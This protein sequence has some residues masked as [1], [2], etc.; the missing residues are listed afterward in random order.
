M[1]TR[2]RTANADLYHSSAVHSPIASTTCEKSMPIDFLEA[3]AAKTYSLGDVF[4]HN[5]PEAI[6]SNQRTGLLFF[7]RDARAING[8][9]SGVAGKMTACFPLTYSL[10]E[11]LTIRW[12]H[13]RPAARSASR[14]LIDGVVE[15]HNF[16]SPGAYLTLKLAGQSRP[17]NMVDLG[18]SLVAPI[19]YRWLPLL[20]AD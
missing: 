15:N 8:A 6:P 4:S 1:Q 14:K 11:K 5:F 12:S 17:A 3:V 20:A 13:M 7:A 2:R 10:R 9:S 19:F 16:D 18:Y